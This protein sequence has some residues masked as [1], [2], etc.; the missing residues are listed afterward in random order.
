MLSVVKSVGLAVICLLM[1]GCFSDKFTRLPAFETGQPQVEKR[2]FERHDPFPDRLSAPDTQVRPR[3]F[4]NQRTEPRR[5][6]EE[7]LFQGTT[8][9]GEFPFGRP[10]LRGSQYRDSVRF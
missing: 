6:L 7:M 4:D 9:N 10:D 2:S 5:A 3:G 8:D 1:A